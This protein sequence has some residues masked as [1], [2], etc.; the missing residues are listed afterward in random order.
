MLTARGAKYSGVANDVSAL[1]GN[2]EWLLQSFYRVSGAASTELCPVVSSV[3]S[4]RL[5]EHKSFYWSFL[6]TT[7]RRSMN[8][9]G[10]PGEIA[11]EQHTTSLGKG[12]RELHLAD[13]PRME[14]RLTTRKCQRKRHDQDS[15]IDDE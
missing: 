10:W 2:G 7:I 12:V 14:G 4:V 13:V 15:A 3:W 8:Y 5:L 6:C 11:L 1:D 9:I